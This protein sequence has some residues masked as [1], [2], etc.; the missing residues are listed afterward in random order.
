[1]AWKRKVGETVDLK[2]KQSQIASRFQPGDVAHVPTA[3][4]QVRQGE[5]VLFGQWPDRFLQRLADSGVQARIRN[6]YLL[7]QRH[8]TAGHRQNTQQEQ[9]RN[10]Q[11]SVHA[12]TAS[13]RDRNAGDYGASHRRIDNGR[14]RFP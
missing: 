9:P 5:Q 11:N 3:G 7:R 8:P 4:V 2:I 13:A 12:F 10:V 1:M 6:E 14:A